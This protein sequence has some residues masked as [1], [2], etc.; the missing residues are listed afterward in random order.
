MK[1]WFDLKWVRAIGQIDPALARFAEM[2]VHALATALL[3]Q[4]GKVLF[5]LNEALQ[6]K[7]AINWQNILLQ[8]D[9]RAVLSVGVVILLAAVNKHVVETRRADPPLAAKL[10]SSSLQSPLPNA[11]PPATDI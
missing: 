4:L 6:G 8:F 11:T 3:F 2:I 7:E 10:A 5:A 1:L 9:W